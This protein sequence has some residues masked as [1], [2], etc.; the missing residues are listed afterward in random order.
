MAPDAAAQPPFPPGGKPAS[1]VDHFLPVLVWD[2]YHGFVVARRDPTNQP[3]GWKLDLPSG[4]EFGMSEMEL[5]Q[6]RLYWLLPERPNLA[7]GSSS[8]PTAGRAGLRGPT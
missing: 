4:Y 6:V 8:H 1:L 5:E 2:D 3:H 7:A